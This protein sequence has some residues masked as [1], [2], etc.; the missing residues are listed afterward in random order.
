MIREKFYY[1]KKTLNYSKVDT[2]KSILKKSLLFIGCAILF[3]QVGFYFLSKTDF[4]ITQK[5][6]IQQRE[7]ENY[8]LQFEFITTRMHH[9][10]EVMS[11]IENRDNNLYRAYFNANP[12]PKEQRLAGFGGINR[13]KKLEGFNNSDLIINTT[14]QLDIL[15]K[16]ILIQSRS[17]DE[18]EK[19]AINKDKF[20]AV[21]PSIQPVRNKDLRRMAS[22]YGWRIDPFTKVR[23][24][25]YGMDFSAKI[26]TPVYA[27]GNGVV[28]RAD[29]KSRGYGNHI[30]IKHGHGYISLYAHLSE[31]NV[32]VNQKVK[33]GD[34]IGFVGNTGRSV[35][36]HLHYEIHKRNKRVNPI[37]FYYGNLSTEEFEALLKA[38]ANETQS[39]D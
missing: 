38:A 26:G 3:G 13:Y 7:L 12:I 21:I 6:K 1:N 15:S 10:E 29:N 27:S 25:H 19:L 22:G 39:L 9:L 5:E 31:Y 33:R 11:N 2:R 8:Q 16:Q 23:K 18:I 32:K 35:A 36:P 37:N 14:K 28:I 34:V 20:L 24:K 4:L 30:R 17:L